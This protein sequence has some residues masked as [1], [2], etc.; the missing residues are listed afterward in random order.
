L[1]SFPATQP[2]DSDAWESALHHGNACKHN[3]KFLL[4]NFI[5]PGSE[6]KLIKNDENNNINKE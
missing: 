2:G 3:K 6:N 1:F 5:I 4:E